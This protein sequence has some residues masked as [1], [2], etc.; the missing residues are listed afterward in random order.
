MKKAGRIL[1]L[2]IILV[3]LATATCFAGT[4]GGLKLTGTYPEDGYKGAATENM[5]VKL[6]FDS[7]LTEE[8]LGEKNANAIK[9]YG[10]DGKAL[11]TRVLYAPKEEGVVLVIVDT[12]EEGNTIRGESNAEYTV[13]IANT[14]V[15]NEGN[16]LGHA[17][18]FTFTTL[19][20]GTN[21]AVSMV[22]MFVMM[23]GM[24]VMTTKAATKEAQKQ[25]EA[26]RERES[27]VN[28][29]KEAKKTGKSVE[30]IVE[31]T[32]KDKAKAE[33][34]AAKKAA[35]QAE[36]EYEFDFDDFDFTEEGVYK[37]K[38]PRPIAA[39]GGKYITGR[40]AEAEAKAAAEAAR[41]EQEAKWAANAKKGKGK[42]KK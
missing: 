18:S 42:K 1:S 26:M 20:E 6:Y 31:Q 41:K 2:A 24:M 29:Y 23:G 3:M 5:G 8:V 40:K 34:K 30:E 27:K 33:A 28:P 21:N 10:P 39:A 22:M 17:E 35:K 38:S 25:A 15:D 11:P 12:D 16:T 4:E 14:M 36:E 13:K 19:N 32:Q 37:V 7:E 9:I